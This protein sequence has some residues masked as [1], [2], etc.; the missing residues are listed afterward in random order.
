MAGDYSEDERGLVEEELVLQ[1]L[2]LS[3]R[4]KWE[5]DGGRMRE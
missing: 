2:T 4:S 3:V 1:A 5:A